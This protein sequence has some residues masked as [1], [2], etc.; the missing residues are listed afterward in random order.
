M[1]V[2]LAEIAAGAI[3]G[4]A[5]LPGRAK[6]AGLSGVRQERSEFASG[7]GRSDNPSFT[8]TRGRPKR[9]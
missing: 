1:A 3:F 7:V 9:R 8:G 6:P 5:V 2:E 4:G